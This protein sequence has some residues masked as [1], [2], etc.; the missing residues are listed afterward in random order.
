MFAK[1]FLILA[2]LCVVACSDGTEPGATQCAANTPRVSGATG[3]S[4][5]AAGAANDALIVPQGLAVTPRPGINSVFNVFALTLRA[6]ANGAE[7]Y[8][9]IRNDGDVLACNASFSVELRD[10]DDLTV[11]TGVS[12]LM[13][14]HFYRFK[15]GSNTLAGCVAG[16][17]M[18][19]V[20]IKGMALDTP[21]EAV[22]SAVYQS[23]YWGNLDLAPIDGVG[24]TGVQS[25]TRGSGVAYTGT[26]VNALDVELSNPTLAVFPRNAVGRPLDV[27][28]GSSSVVLSPCGTWDFETSTVSEAGV[29]FDGYAMGGP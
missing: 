25:V 21:I 16:G 4:G 8:A 1:F 23:N 3:E 29:G 15:D 20:A 14:T 27:A 5:G 22:V 17:D 2:A 18:T 6:T 24:L 7:L 26:L 10:K 28:Y 11:G 9:A 19:M 12:G 13:S